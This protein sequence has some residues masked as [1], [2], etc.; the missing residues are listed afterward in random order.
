MEHNHTAHQKTHE[1]HKEPGLTRLAVSAT[2]HCLLGCG[3]GEVVGMIIGA[4]LLLSNL[5][6]IILS[7][8]LGFIGGLALG[9]VPL[10]RRNIS[11]S[12]SVRIVII[13]EGLS[14]A[15]MEFFEVMTQVLIPG[16]MEAHLHEPVFWL[17]M[18]AALVVG[19]FAALPV[20]IIMIR[21][22]VRHVH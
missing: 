6:T 18:G 22:G 9:V 5:H 7:V 19:F 15:V 13:G 21:K 17:G 2:F 4:W 11:F 14:I 16:V 3:I 8:I 20:N 10:L 1:M 12:K